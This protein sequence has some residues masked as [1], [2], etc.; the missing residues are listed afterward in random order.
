MDDILGR[1]LTIGALILALLFVPLVL[2][3]QKTEAIKQSMMETAV[4]EFVDNCRGTGKISPEDYEKMYAEVSK[5]VEFA[6][7]KLEHASKVIGYED[8]D[9]VEYFVEFNNSEILSVMYDSSATENKDYKLR[10]GDYLTLTVRNT[11]PTM[12][13]K[14]TPGSDRD[15]TLYYTYSGTVGNYSEQR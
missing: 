5:Y 10:N 1:I 9:T 14:L 13:E 15:T 12:A 3:L 11:K 4:V 8:G 7:I 6:E 2:F